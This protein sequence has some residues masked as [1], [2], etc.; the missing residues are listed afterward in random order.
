[1]RKVKT[2]E[3]L[4]LFHENTPIAEIT[5]IP[6]AMNNMEIIFKQENDNLGKEKIQTNE[7]FLYDPNHTM[8][9]NTSMEKRKPKHEFNEIGDQK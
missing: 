5:A 8:E 9:E 4:T 2:L 7:W 1:M 3:S 6:T